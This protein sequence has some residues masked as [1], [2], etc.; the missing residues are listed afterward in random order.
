MMVCQVQ[1]IQHSGIAV[2]CEGYHEG[3]TLPSD[4]SEVMYVANKWN[5]CH[6]CGNE[7]HVIKHCQIQPYQFR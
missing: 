4:A 2:G 7:D 6:Q 3:L 1:D 5:D